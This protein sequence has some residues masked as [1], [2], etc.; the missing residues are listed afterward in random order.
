M[1][2]AKNIEGIILNRIDSKEEWISKKRMALLT[3][4]PVKDPE[5]KLHELDFDFKYPADVKRVHDPI[6]KTI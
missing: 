5:R 4:I 2:K 1:N 6:D 3:L